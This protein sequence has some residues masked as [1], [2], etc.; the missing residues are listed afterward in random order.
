MILKTSDT[1]DKGH[2]INS[3]SL[4]TEGYNLNVMN[5]PLQNQ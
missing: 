2:S 3:Q 4:T 5:I 1:D